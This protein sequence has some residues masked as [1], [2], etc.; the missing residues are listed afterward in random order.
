[1]K[2]IGTEY[3][4]QYLRMKQGDE[5]YYANKRKAAAI[6][7]S[8]SRLSPQQ[9]KINTTAM[10]LSNIKRPTEMH[11]LCLESLGRFE[12][13]KRYKIVMGAGAEML[14]PTSHKFKNWVEFLKYFKRFK[15]K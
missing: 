9:A 15:T 4:D 2:Y 3:F 7:G 5:E 14:D 13:G 6:G 1:M 10:G 8:L 11:V 12:K